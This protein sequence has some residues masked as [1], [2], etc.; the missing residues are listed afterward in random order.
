M[1]RFW[2][3]VDVKGPDECWEWQGGT[4]SHGYGKFTQG[5]MWEMLH[6]RMAYT[7]RFGE[8]PSGQVVRHKC[9]NKLCANPHHLELGTQ[10]DNVRDAYER[11][12]LNKQLTSD[13]VRQIRLRL[14]NGKRGIGKVLAAEFGTSPDIISRINT[15]K[16]YQEAG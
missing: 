1:K 8:I 13:Q 4:G 9:D 6:H 15:G 10:A 16:I 2:D 11:G 14:R 5:R 3:K 12:Q 7:L